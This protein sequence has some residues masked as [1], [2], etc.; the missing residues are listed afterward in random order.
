MTLPINAAHEGPQE[1]LSM[2]TIKN[3]SSIR[4]L[5]QI[6]MYQR[7]E[8]GITAS[9]KVREIYWNGILCYAL[10]SES[11]G[12]WFSTFGTFGTSI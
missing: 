2:S 10:T 1:Q 9:S 7:K 4:L 12:R 5:M 11:V 8:R 3:I 6:L